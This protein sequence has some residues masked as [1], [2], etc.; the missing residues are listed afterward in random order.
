MKRLF[1]IMF[2][3]SALLLPAF[4]RA[5]ISNAGIEDLTIETYPKNPGAFTSTTISLSSYSDFVDTAKIT[6]KLNGKLMLSGIGKKQYSFTTGSFG[7]A[8]VIEVVLTPTSGLPTTKRI[9]I[10]PMGIDLLWEATDSIVPPMYRGKALPASES[11]IRIVA[12]PQIK[13][14]SGN[15]IDQYNMLY[16]WK[17]NYE[18]SVSDSGFGKNSFDIDTSYLN[19][20]EHIEVSASTRDGGSSID[21]DI[22][23]RTGN[24][25]IIW[26]PMSPLYGPIFEHAI[27]GDYPVA[28]SSIS[29]LAEPY[30]FSPG[31]PN[32]KSLSYEWTLNGQKIDTPQIPNT[33]FLQRNNSSKGTAPV[34]VLVSSIE[35]LFQE[36]TARVNL[37]LK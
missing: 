28:A 22:N 12:I 13:S 35:N 8:S 36:T 6:W 26:Y 1:A 33:L 18:Q 2:F 19:P 21:T 34:S 7:T 9:Q 30:F 31:N 3:A 20:T 29:I 23:I 5:Q 27:T 11:K 25:F 15:L 16:N 24:P 4:S 17:Q 10:T 14:D 32:S 37:I